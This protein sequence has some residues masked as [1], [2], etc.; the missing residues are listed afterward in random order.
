M[1]I[2]G[3]FLC[4]SAVFLVLTIVMGFSV[5]FT[6]DNWRMVDTRHR[7]AQ[8]GWTFLALT[9]LFALTGIW[10]SIL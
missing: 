10:T 5:L 7:F 3:A 4:T 1:T 6:E 8:F 2:A 9:S